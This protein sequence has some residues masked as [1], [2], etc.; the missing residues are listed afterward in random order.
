[1]YKP[2]QAFAPTAELYE[3]LTA[4]AMQNL[5]RASLTEI[6]IPAGS[7]V[8]DNGCGVGVGSEALLESR[9]D[10]SIKATDIEDVALKRYEERGAAWPAETSHMDAQALTFP[11][12]ILSPTP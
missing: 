6:D 10:I 11:E 7:V 2:K 1:M 8:H 12:H 4:D 5:G 9:G 3:E